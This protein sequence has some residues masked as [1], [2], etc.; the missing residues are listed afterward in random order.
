MYS[1]LESTSSRLRHLR[2]LLSPA[3]WFFSPEAEQVKRC[4]E[5]LSFCPSRDEQP[6]A[7]IWVSRLFLPSFGEAGGDHQLPS[8]R[9][10]AGGALSPS[11]ARHPL[12][13]KP[14]PWKLCLLL[15]PASPAPR[16]QPRVLLTSVLLREAVEGRC[17]TPPKLNPAALL[18][19]CEA[20][21][22]LIFLSVNRA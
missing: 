15:T 3:P 17:R 13:W 11:L 20:F 1:L 9:P 16:L 14:S 10:G 5:L 7:T 18:G 4:Q 21:F 2:E 8:H 12:S 6:P 19:G 22:K